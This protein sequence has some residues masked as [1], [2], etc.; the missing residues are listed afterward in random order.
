MELQAPNRGDFS[1]LARRK[2]PGVLLFNF[3]YNGIAR[4]SMIFLQLARLVRLV[5]SFIRPRASCSDSWTALLR[6][7]PPSPIKI[8]SKLDIVM[9][10]Q[11]LQ[12]APPCRTGLTSLTILLT[13]DLSYW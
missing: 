9:D 2:I 10:T 12:Y 6:A 3:V 11:F 13:R 8:P 1:K 5:S 7:K 4:K